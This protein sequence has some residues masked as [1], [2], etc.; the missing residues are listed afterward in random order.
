MDETG[1]YVVFISGVCGTASDT[2]DV[3]AITLDFEASTVCGLQSSASAELDPP[4][5]GVWS[6]PENISFSNANLLNTQISSSLFGIYPITYTDDRCPAD[7]VTHDFNFVEQPEA[8]IIPANPDFCVDLDELILSATVNGSFNGTYI[9]NVNGTQ[10]LSQNDSLF[11]PVE[12]FDPLEDYLISVLVQDAF[13][14]CPLATGETNFTGKWCTYNIPNVVTPNGDNKNDRF[15]VEFIEYF[16]NT[17]LTVYDRWGKT[18]FEQANYDK[19]Q[20]STGG[21]DPNDVNSGTYFYELLIPHVDRI[22]SGYVQVLKDGSG[23]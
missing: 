19:Y 2:T 17:K 5:P 12:Y 4:G 21:W 16:P 10:Q 15:H 18:V 20:A 1:L 13:S 14:V 11:F 22:E 8:V 3:V 23:D 6:G 9:W 7:E